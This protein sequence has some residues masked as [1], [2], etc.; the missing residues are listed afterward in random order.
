ML[1]PGLELS[2]ISREK[3]AKWEYTEVGNVAE[4]A[5]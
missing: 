2:Q 1:A 3:L 4:L 5:M